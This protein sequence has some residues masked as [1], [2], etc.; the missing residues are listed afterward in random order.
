MNIPPQ[1]IDIEEQIISSMLIN[2]EDLEQAL[3]I[4]DYNDFYKNSHSL[5][6][7]T[8][9]YL[10]NRRDPIEPLTISN[11]LKTQDRLTEIGGP[12]GL[13]K[14]LDLPQAINIEF[15]CQR[16]KE[17]S[18]RRQI[19][20]KCNEI[21]KNCFDLNNEALHVLDTAQR[22]IL[23]IELTTKPEFYEIKDLVMDVSDKMESI[24]KNKHVYSGVTTG[25]YALDKVTGGMQNSDLIIVAGRPGLG[26]TA[27]VLNIARN[28]ARKGFASGIFELE[29][30]K[31][32][33]VYRM[34][35]SDSG[36]NLIKFRNGGFT[37]G[38]FMDMN[39]AQSALYDTN[40]I[41]DDTPSLTVME[42]KR[43]ARKMKKDNNI[44]MIVIDYLTLMKIEST[45]KNRSNEVGEV[46]R[47]LKGLAKELNIPVILLCQLNRKV[48]ERS[49]KKPMLSDLRDSGEIEEHADV[50]MLLYRDDYY[51]KDENNP[52]KGIAEI[53]IA[54]QRNGPVCMVELKWDAKATRFDNLERGE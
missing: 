50:I 6:F 28:G 12:G 44:N 26:K 39:L 23:K 31:E 19:I 51:N 29:M 34:L 11:V 2:P 41:I 15:A 45:K 9:R 42:I 21:S 52:L 20:E 30:S 22:D 48:E 16:I 18:V 17:H 14:F 1:D 53:N 37:P 54:K 4:L 7:R 35:A 24:N 13:S 5:I 25:F 32:Q 8:C 40:I 33:L 3:D 46:T 36:I 49:I 43:R 47:E 38:D 27:F 10:H